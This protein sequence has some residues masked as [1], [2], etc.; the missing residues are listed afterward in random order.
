[1]LCLEF[2][3]AA[4]RTWDDL[5][6]AAALKTRLA[7]ESITD[8]LVFQLA[9]GQIFGNY[10]VQSFTKAEESINGADWELWLTGPSGAW[11]GLRIQA[12]VMK[13]GANRFM[14]LHKPKPIAGA[15]SATQRLI[16][17]ANSV[18]AIPLY[19]LYSAW[20]PTPKAP[21]WA[22]GSYPPDDRLWGLSFV[23]A[24][25][26]LT[27]KPKTTLKALAPHMQTAH[28]MF[29]CSAY[30]G[31]DLPTKAHSFASARFSGSDPV[32]LKTQP[33][34]LQHFLSGARDVA[35]GGNQEWPDR[36]LGRVTVIRQNA[37]QIPG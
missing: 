3:K 6:T 5:I 13:V 29:C 30:G 22:C 19:L 4:V 34:H 7:E 35:D 33:T 1:M 25:D 12:K 20:T 31:T 17:S 18:D 14:Q 37:I 15:L 23:E 28:C 24:G 2:R 32:L 9:K 11:F 16:N 26:V 27:L 8:Y 10:Q 36:N 21:V